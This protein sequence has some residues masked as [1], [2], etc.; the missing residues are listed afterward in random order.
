VLTNLPR[1]IVRYRVKAPVTGFL[2]PFDATSS[3]VTFPIGTLLGG[4]ARSSD[5]LLGMSLVLWQGRKYS[6][7]DRELQHRCHRID[8]TDAS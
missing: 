7:F 6:V 8:E 4:L 5:T 2:V 3:S 1:R